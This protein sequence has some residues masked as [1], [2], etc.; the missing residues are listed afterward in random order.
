MPSPPAKP[1]VELE[2]DKIDVEV[3]AP[4]A[5]V[6]SRIDRKDGEDVKVGEVLGVLDESAKARGD[7][8]ERRR[9][10]SAANDRRPAA[11][12]GDADGQ[13]G[14]GRERSR[15]RQ[16]PRQRRRRPRDAPRRRAGRRDRGAGACGAGAS[17]ACAA[18]AQPV[19][20]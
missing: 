10:R 4:H 3:S 7:A 15:S 17:R 8:G 12:P 20:P 2:T 19:P 14:G 16:R 13:K 1:L 9:G 11:P 18:K 6:L 5:G